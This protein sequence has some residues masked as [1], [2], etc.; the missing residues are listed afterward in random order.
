MRSFRGALLGLP[1]SEG[2]LL[3]HWDRSLAST[4]AS[5]GGAIMAHSRQEVAYFKSGVDCVPG[6][7]QF[8][9]QLRL[10][11]VR[12]VPLTGDKPRK[13][14]VCAHTR[15]CC[16]GFLLGLLGEERRF[17]LA[18]GFLSRL[19]ASLVLG[20]T[21]LAFS[22]VNPPPLAALDMITREEPRDSRAAHQRTAEKGKGR[23]TQRLRNTAS[24]R[25]E[26]EQ[27]ARCD[28][29]ISRHHAQRH[30]PLPA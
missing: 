12:E 26:I 10:S 5:G 14:R 2:R 6:I 17:V 4:A 8:G 13:P 20:P 11:W 9:Y 18:T 27:E 3:M 29:S 16:C 23:H 25:E 7:L 1:A 30:P 15:L 24:S 21:T 22:T 19:A 28:S